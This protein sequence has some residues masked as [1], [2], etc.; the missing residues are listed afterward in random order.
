MFT[1]LF[2]FMLSALQLPIP[3]VNYPRPSAIGQRP[4]VN[5]LPSTVIC[6]PST[7]Y[8]PIDTTQLRREVV[9]EFEKQPKGVF[10]VAFKDLSTGQQFF[11][12]EHDNFHAASTM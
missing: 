7:A 9:A 5:E 10:A 11:I 8:K 1:T 4:S 12:N 6:Q 3:N 2:S